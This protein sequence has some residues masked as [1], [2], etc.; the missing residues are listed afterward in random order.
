MT[1]AR[2]MGD[3]Q[4]FR[5]DFLNKQAVIDNG[6]IVVGTP[7]IDNGA[8]LNGATDYVDYPD[9][10]AKLDTEGT[11][12][13][14]IFPLT[15]GSAVG[16]FIDVSDGT[17]DN[18]V[19]VYLGGGGASLFIAIIGDGVGTNV[20][21]HTSATSVLTNNITQE[22]TVVFDTVTDTYSLY[23]D[24]ALITPTSTSTAGN[25]VNMSQVRVGAFFDGSVLYAGGIKDVRLLDTKWTAEEALDEYENDTYT[26]VD[27]SKFKMFL[28]LRGTFDNGSG[29]VTSN[30]GTIGTDAVVADGATA[31]VITPLNG[32]EFDGVDDFMSIGTLSDFSF[33]QN[34]MVFTMGLMVFIPDKDEDILSSFISNTPTSAD[35]GVFFAYENR[36]VVS[37]PAQ[38]RCYVNNGSSGDP[39]IASDGSA[40]VVRSGW[41]FITATGD[42][43]NVRFYVND[44]SE[45]GTDTVGTLATGD[46]TRFMYVGATNF[47]TPIGYLNGKIKFPFIT[48]FTMTPRQVRWMQQRMLKEFNI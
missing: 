30:L 2:N 29:V 40:G 8:L 22:L 38:V 28:P 5:E 37:N 47:T 3:K 46:T 34:T 43:T 10:G 18:R 26:E 23:V 45:I 31:P 4:L 16:G 6:G 35:N 15:V 14:K 19:A 48:D 32:M 20:W 44:F 13:F 17:S 39:V 42:G 33:I 12:N 21:T 9:Y 27:V 11:I 24:G 41:N 25:P 7:T 36:T 1:Y